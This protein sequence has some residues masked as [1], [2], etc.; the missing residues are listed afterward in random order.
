[1]MPT[2]D[3]LRGRLR[4]Y[5]DAINTRDPQVIAAFFTEDA[6]QA[7]PVSN[8]PAIGRAAIANFFEN[9]I[10][11]SDAW[12]FTAKSVHTCADHL[13]IDFAIA[14]ETG[15]VT[16]TIEGIEIFSTN[17]DGL[18]TDVRAYWDEADVTVP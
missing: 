6:V 17:E 9:G 12:T 18:F 11:A 5:V 15:G 14:V 4:A 13:A 2:P 8:P 1:M 10:A 7:D 3:D 16:M